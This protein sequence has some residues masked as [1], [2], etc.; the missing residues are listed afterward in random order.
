MGEAFITRRGGGGGRLVAFI[1][2]VYPAGS[3]CACSNGNKILKAKDTS[4]QF[5]FEIPEIGTWTVGCTD[6]SRS[7]SYSVNVSL[8]N[9]YNVTLRYTVELFNA[10]LSGDQTSV[11]GGWGMQHMDL[12]PSVAGTTPT[13]S[14]TASNIT[15]TTNNKSGYGAVRTN[16]H[17]YIARSSTLYVHITAYNLDKEGHCA[18]VAMSGSTVVASTNLGG[19]GT[20][21]LSLSPGSYRIGIRVR[22]GASA[23]CSTSR[24]VT[25]HVWIG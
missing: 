7:D 8:H 16:N 25:D 6:G 20:Y 2:V 19:T 10:S 15:V 11:T 1:N 13:F 23:G 24:Y 5:T 22:Q 12:A 9:A 4:G 17:I 21:A 18:V 14:V 3:I